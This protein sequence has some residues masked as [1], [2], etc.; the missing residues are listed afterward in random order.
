[1][2]VE[3]YTN[4]KLFDFFEWSFKLIIWNLL[5]VFIT[6]ITFGIVF[7]P[8]YYVLKEGTLAV[9]LYILAI[10]LAVFIFVPSFSTIFSCIKIYKEDGYA[11]TFALFFDRL[12]DN[13]KALALPTLFMMGVAS[14]FL[15]AI[16]VDYMA[17]LNEE[18][19]GA[20]RVVCTV[21]YYVLIIVV[22]I[23][24]LMFL[25]VPMVVSH[26]R[27]KM[28]TLLLFT[29]RITF[30]KIFS[31]VLYLL[32]LVM[33]LLLCTFV[34]FLFPIWLLIGFSVP[35]FVSYHIARRDYWKLVKNIGEINKE[36][37]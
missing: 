25:N 27:M 21:S 36:D 11:E 26:F 9:V 37:F 35:L 17:L 4:S 23:I 24:F 6:G 14:I 16:Y 1:M 18:I 5:V 30:Q 34:N 7:F 15:G 20:T 31:T 33:P 29:L 32:L 2:D 19:V 28:W 8:T 22:F 13:I 3:K 10:L 12:W